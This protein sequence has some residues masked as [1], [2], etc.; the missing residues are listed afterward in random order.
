MGAISRNL[1]A[2]AYRKL[3][4]AGVRNL[5]TSQ[6][7]L[8]ARDRPPRRMDRFDDGPVLVVAPH[9][10]DEIC[11]CGG[12]MGRHVAANQ[13]VTVVFVTDGSAGDPDLRG[14]NGDPDAL[15][16]ARAALSRRREA[17]SRAA[18]AEYGVTD[19]R[20][21][22]GPDG[23]LAP[24]EALVN[25]MC[26]VLDE[27]RPAIL[28]HPSLLD[29]HSDHW[30]S[31]LILARAL[32]ASRARVPEPVLR[33]YEV[34]TPAIPNRFA[35]ITEEMPRKERAFRHFE[36]QNRTIDYPRAIGG[37]NSYRS[38]CFQGG[39]GFSEAFQEL[40]VAEFERLLAAI[41]A[42]SHAGRS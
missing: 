12:V 26:A 20:L 17:E 42:Q 36:S 31:N 11:G 4:P 24:T 8:T 39:R 6:I 38:I 2:A 34:W 29:A 25:A 23:A 37:L 10:D 27:S 5:L 16:V 22:G 33:G 35:D 21:L 1:I 18:C 19:I 14:S 13:P 41:T 32:K 28:Y 40:T 9:F 30:A 7:L 15:R 3:A